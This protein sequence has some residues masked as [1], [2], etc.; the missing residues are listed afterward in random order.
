MEC[1]EIS[2]KKYNWNRKLPESKRKSS[3]HTNDSCVQKTLSIN[4]YHHLTL[5][6]IS[7]NLTFWEQIQWVHLGLYV[8]YSA[9]SLFPPLLFPSSLSLFVRDEDVSTFTT[10]PISY[11]FPSLS[12]LLLLFIVPLFCILLYHLF[13]L[14]VN[15]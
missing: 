12:H 4:H 3:I 1:E 8:H 9:P 15:T 5:L 13:Y 7:S 10:D 14:L 6:L 11:I 2:T